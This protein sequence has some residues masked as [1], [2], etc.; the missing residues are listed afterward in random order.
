[1]NGNIVQSGTPR[2][3][4]SSPANEEIAKFVGVENILEGTVTSNKDCLA[5]IKV[6][7]H[8]IE[9]VSSCQTGRRVSVCIRPEDITLSLAKSST[10][11]RNIFPCRITSM[12]SSGPL[13]RVSLDCGFPLLALITGMSAEE[14]KLEVGKTV[15]ASFKATA[16][17]VISTR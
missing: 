10:S 14:L 13:V 17:H 8:I 2:E 9:G 12:I 16:I 1:M 3:V 7:D 5:D 11:A 6:R 4:F 15:Y